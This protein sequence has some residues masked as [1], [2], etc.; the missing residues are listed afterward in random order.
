M[1]AGLSC[2]EFGGLYSLGDD[3]GKCWDDEMNAIMNDGEDLMNI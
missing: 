2:D 1:V 3:E